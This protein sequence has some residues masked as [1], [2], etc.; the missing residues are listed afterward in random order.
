[1][2]RTAPPDRPH[3]V[4]VAGPDTPAT[5]AAARRG[6][7]PAVAPEVRRS[8]TIGVCVSAAE[9]ARLR[10]V[11]AQVG[12]KPSAFLRAAA[13]GVVPRVVPEGNRTHWLALGK[14][15]ATLTQLMGARTR[16][17]PV[18][19][20]ERLVAALRAE[21]RAL[22]CALLGAE[23]GSAWGST[24]A[25][26]APTDVPPGAPCGAPFDVLIGG[27]AVLAVPAEVPT[28]SVQGSQADSFRLPNSAAL[29][30]NAGAHHPPHSP[31]FG[32]TA[33]PAAV[34]EV[35]GD[36]RPFWTGQGGDTG[37]MGTADARGIGASGTPTALSPVPR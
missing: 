27:A 15:T 17:L 18:T 16:G 31:A 19:L 34:P 7:R 28:S 37:P 4:P 8:Q 32:I 12:M 30:G 29:R 20:D 14:L 36:A 3:T 26:D 11:A 33:V 10:R 23:D 13:L 5:R 22:R 35:A 2:P 9:A 25:D 6:G 1:M 21:V 24:G